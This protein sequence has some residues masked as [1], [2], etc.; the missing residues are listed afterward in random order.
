MT[1][2]NYSA[3]HNS[4]IA[5]ESDEMTTAEKETHP[6]TSDDNLDWHQDDAEP[7]EEI[8]LPP[9]ATLVA[10]D[11]TELEGALENNSPELHSFLNKKSGDVIRI[12]NGTENAER[13]LQE[14]EADPAYVYIEPISSREQYRWMEEYIEELE[15]CPLKDK[16]N[17]AVDGKG[18][19]RRFKDVLVQDA[20]KREIWFAKRS[21]KLQ[22]HI[23]EWLKAKNIVASNPAP[24]Q[25]GAST[26]KFETVRRNR[27]VAGQ[28]KNF[29]TNLRR[30][31]HELVD[32][33]PSKALPI[34]ASFLEFLANEKHTFNTEE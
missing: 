4:V 12:F 18:A 6:V 14:V 32:L 7:S 2:H 9:G 16:L 24:W 17:I 29:G 19:F 34:A 27:Y 23:A 15:D 26:R 20:D 13:R 22:A 25:E 1:E 21:E 8:Q 30:K 33:V 11:W 31:A 5:H 10:V 3:E 28:T